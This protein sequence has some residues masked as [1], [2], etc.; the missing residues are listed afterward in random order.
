MPKEKLTKSLTKKVKSNIKSLNDTTIARDREE[1]A[2]PWFDEYQDCFDFKFKPITQKFIERLCQELIVWARTDN[3]AFRIEDFYYDRGICESTYY[4]WVAKHQDLKTAHEVA[5]NS[6]AS[7]REKGALKRELSEKMVL[8]SL[9]RYDKRAKED[10]K[11][12][13]Q[14]K[15]EALTDVEGRQVIVLPRIVDERLEKE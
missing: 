9:P 5:M 6:L 4:R 11:F 8:Q 10:A 2:A 3:D 7:R 12:H 15:V 13:A 14:L 1:S